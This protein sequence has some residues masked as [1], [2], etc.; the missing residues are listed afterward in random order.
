M[1]GLVSE[2]IDTED[3]DFETR[4][5]LN[6]GVDQMTFRGLFHPQLFLRICDFIL[7]LPI[8]LAF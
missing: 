8:N 5:T 7:P 3:A 6:R 4:L 1:H 2:D